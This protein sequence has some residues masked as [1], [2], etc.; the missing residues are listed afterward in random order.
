VTD[1]KDEFEPVLIGFFCN[2]CTATAAD[3][4]GT[5]RLQYPP[6]IRPIRVMCSSTVDPVYV[7]RALLSGADGVIVGG[8]TPGDCHYISG[9]YKASRRLSILKTVLKTLGLDDDRVWVRWIS[10]AQ[11]PKFAA[12]MNEFTEEMKKK[13]PSP[14]GKKWSV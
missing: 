7:L 9:N 3:L 6:N 10:A 14:L 1:K 2:W 5:T 13:G 4:A 11:G 12:T 8:C